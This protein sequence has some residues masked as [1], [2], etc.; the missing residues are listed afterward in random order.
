[1]DIKPPK[2]CNFSFISLNKTLLESYAW[3]SLSIKQIQ[4]FFYLS[5]CLVWNREKVAGKKQW[6]AVNNGD[7]EVSTIKMRK[8]LNQSKQTCSKAVHKLIEVGLIRLTRVGE[9]KTCHKYKILYQ[10]VPQREQRWKKYPIENWKHECPKSPNILAGKETRIGGESDPTKLDPDSVK[11]TNGVDLNGVNGKGK[12]TQKDSI[13]DD[14]QS[15]RV[16][17]II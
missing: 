16:G 15:S 9:N 5:S 14:E 12:L 11:R 4:V 10:I 8:S 2:Y 13:D 1:M 17:S 3:N 7:I 6:I